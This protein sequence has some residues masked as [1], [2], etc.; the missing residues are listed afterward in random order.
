MSATTGQIVGYRLGVIQIQPGSIMHA[1][2]IWMM[3]TTGCALSVTVWVFPWRCGV[4]GFLSLTVV[5]WRARGVGGRTGFLRFIAD[6]PQTWSEPQTWTQT[7]SCRVQC[8]YRQTTTITHTDVFG[9]H[10]QDW[11]SSSHTHSMVINPWWY[12]CSISEMSLF[13]GGKGIPSC[14]PKK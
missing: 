11:V 9:E 6:C 13:C 12:Q 8:V 5:V 10:T 14:F 3:K 1:T 4:V 2:W 7:P